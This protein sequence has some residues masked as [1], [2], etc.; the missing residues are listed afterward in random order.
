MKIICVYPIEDDKSTD[1]L[2]PIYKMLKK[3]PDINFVEYRLQNENDTDEMI[4]DISAKD[5]SLI[6][7]MGHGSSLDLQQNYKPILKRD[8]LIILKGKRVF[9]LS[10]RS[11]ELLK[12]CGVPMKEYIGFGDMLTSW[13]EIMAERNLDANAYKGIT[14]EHI[15]LF[16]SI[17]TNSVCQSL[18]K[19]IEQKKSFQYLFLKIKIY[20]N[21]E[22]TRLLLDKQVVGY[23]ILVERLFDLK[24]NLSLSDKLEIEPLY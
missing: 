24:Y 20:L 8:S 6:I 17:L 16:N 12:K 7:Y 18:A 10:C 19:T 14:E 1:F 21:R 13:Q 22:I 5:E 2:E 23:E 15:E 3:I 9:F 11:A 4:Q